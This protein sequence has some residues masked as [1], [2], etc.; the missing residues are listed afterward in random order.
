MKTVKWMSL[1]LIS[2]VFTAVS[3]WWY[4]RHDLVYSHKNKTGT[5]D[6]NSSAETALDQKQFEESLRPIKI[7]EPLSDIR[8]EELDDG[9]TTEKPVEIGT[10][11]KIDYVGRL[12]HGE[13]FDS[14]K[15]RNMAYE[16]DVGKGRAL[17]GLEL[18]ILGMHKN[19]KR[20]IFVPPQFGY[21]EKGAGGG[22]VPPH[23]VLI[24]DVEILEINR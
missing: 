24:Y 18:G 10:H 22:L 19:G 2:L 21:G 3:V 23:A 4:A 15:R 13:I 8:S 6:K 17:P 11:V 5:Q 14:T 20:R 12:P 1:W 9:N 7:P 16:I